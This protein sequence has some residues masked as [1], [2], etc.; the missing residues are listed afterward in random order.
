MAKHQ[1]QSTLAGYTKSFQ[2]EMTF[3]QR[4]MHFD[5]ISFTRIED[6]VTN[7]LLPSFFDGDTPGRA[8]TCMRV[9]NGGMGILNQVKESEFNWSSSNEM[10]EYLVKCIVNFKSF[11]SMENKETIKM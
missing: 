4:L 1:P 10:T 6:I 2:H 5:E 8:I 9:K 7:V 11:N 3:L